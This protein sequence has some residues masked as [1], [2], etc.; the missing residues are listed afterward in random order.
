MNSKPI[1][2]NDISRRKSAFTQ[3]VNQYSEQLYWKI[4]NIVGR[5]E[6]ADDILQNSFL[7]AWTRLDDFRGDSN[8]YT[9]LYRICVNESLDFLRKKKEIISSEEV[10]QIVN[11]HKSDD[12]FDGND[13]Q[14]KLY[15]AIE[16]LP[17]AQRLAFTMRY[18]DD[19]SYAEMS[20]I[21]GTSEG[22][23]KTNYHLAVKKIKDFFHNND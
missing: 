1:D 12:Y 9:W 19:L 21:T 16:T 14:R 23:L 22:G 17:D 11:N 13:V 18:F 8:L 5:H 15:R 3:I 2:L 6:D 7:K 10:M 4:R 20:D